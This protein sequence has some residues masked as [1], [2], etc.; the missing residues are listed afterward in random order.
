MSIS[1]LRG[2]KRTP[3]ASK[4]LWKGLLITSSFFYYCNYALLMLNNNKKRGQCAAET[5]SNNTYVLNTFF[6]SVLFPFSPA[7]NIL[8][9]NRKNKQK[10]ENNVFP[11]LPLFTWE[12]AELRFGLRQKAG[13]KGN[14]FFRRQKDQSKRERIYIYIWILILIWTHI[15]IRCQIVDVF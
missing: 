11:F 15:R 3:Q 4:V 8:N 5:L 10:T 2:D 7:F 1:G 13:R 6:C 14:P 9:V 12:P